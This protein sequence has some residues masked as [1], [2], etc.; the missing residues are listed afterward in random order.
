[1]EQRSMTASIDLAASISVQRRMAFEV[2]Q[3][4]LIKRSHCHPASLEKQFQR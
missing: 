3:K 2:N 4:T 1:M